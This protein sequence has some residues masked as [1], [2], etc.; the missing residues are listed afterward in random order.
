MPNL[1]TFSTVLMVC[2][3]KNGNNGFQLTYHVVLDPTTLNSQGADR[4]TQYRSAIFYHSPEQKEIAEKITAEVQ[5]KHFKGKK[6]V[7]EIVPAGVFYDA[8][9]YHQVRFLIL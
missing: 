5:E 1:S 2:E 8:E 3:F 9:D 7:T 6:I 4:G